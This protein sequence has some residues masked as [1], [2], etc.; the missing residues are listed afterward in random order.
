MAFVTA[1][2][3]KETSVSTGTGN[4]SLDGAVS[5]FEAFGDNFTL[6]DVF[7][8]AIY[9]EV[10]GDFEVG[11]GSFSVDTSTL[12]RDT[13]LASSNANA[14]VDFAAGTKVV[15]VTAPASKLPQ[16]SPSTASPSN[17]LNVTATEFQLDS[18]TFDV[19]STFTTVD[20][21][22]FDVDVSGSIS[23]DASTAINFDQ[24]G[25]AKAVFQNVIDEVQFKY[26]T[27]N[28]VEGTGSYNT[29]V[30]TFNN[31]YKDG[32]LWWDASNGG[33]NI[34]NYNSSQ[35]VQVNIYH[36]GD[37]RVQS[38]SSPFG[39]GTDIT[40]IKADYSSVQLYDAGNLCLTTQSSG[41]ILVS[42]GVYSNF[43]DMG[44]D[45]KVLLGDG[46]DFNL[47]YTDDGLGTEDAYINVAP[48]AARL[49]FSRGTAGVDEAAVMYMDTDGNFVPANTAAIDLGTA[50]LRW[51]DIYTS[52]LNLSNGI[53]DYTIVEGEDD[54][55][56]YNNKK[57]KVFKFALIEVDTDEAPPKIKDL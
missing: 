18:T 47:Y 3:I 8:Y 9:D 16:I 11:E 56:L 25:T 19:N 55:Y 30:V 15:F 51:R 1:D 2:R 53:G 41:S 21:T 20:G 34:A 43:L 6:S 12:V 37:F 24:N 35:G 31:D 45:D 57:G 7:Y 27:L 50:D 33:L 49:I 36:A 23:L 14:A 29:N 54:L 32:S 38:N 5:G 4:F 40:L 26:D 46:D 28:L 13:I 22:Q 42:G 10:A 39:T 44:D 48:A 17:T 52:D